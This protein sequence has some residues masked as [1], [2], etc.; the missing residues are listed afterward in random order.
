VS[1][2]KDIIKNCKFITSKVEE[3]FGIKGSNEPDSTF[4]TYSP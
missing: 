4:Q 3:L 2:A 1:G